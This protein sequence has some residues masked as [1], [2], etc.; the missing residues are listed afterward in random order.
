MEEYI[1]QIISKYI[2]RD[3]IITKAGLRSILY[4]YKNMNNLQD[5][6]QKLNFTEY[7]DKFASY[8]SNTVNYNYEKHVDQFESLDLFDINFSMVASLLH[9]MKHSEH[10]RIMDNMRKDPYNRLIGVDPY[11]M[12]YNLLIAD[13]YYY[14]DLDLNETV[15]N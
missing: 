15:L 7:N 5:Y 14:F 2:D 12:I 13:S 4:I 1:Y 3:E 6:I 9:E 10:R 11:S 8:G